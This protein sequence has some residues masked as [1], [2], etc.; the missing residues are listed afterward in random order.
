MGINK[1]INRKLR[2]RHVGSPPFVGIAGFTRNDLAKLFGELGYKKGVEV[3]VASGKFS[4]I[5]CQSIPGL[6]LIC[7]DP[8]GPLWNSP[9]TQKRNDINYQWAQKRL[10]GYKADLWKMP[11]MEAVEQFMEH[12]TLDFVYID[13]LHDFDS[14]MRDIIEWTKRVKPGGIVSGHDYIFDCAKEFGVLNAVNNYTYA[15]NI[16]EWWITKDHPNSWFFV[17]K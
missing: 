6:K 17:K 2:V 10:K 3:G 4:E 15:H 1:I 14:A 9:I 12:N 11:S 7:V 13:G 16:T 5:L 8:W